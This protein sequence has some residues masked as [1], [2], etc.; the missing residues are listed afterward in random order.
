MDSGLLYPYQKLERLKK[1]NSYTT[2]LYI[3]YKFKNLS[4]VSSK[5]EISFPICFQNPFQLNFVL[6][7]WFLKTIVFF[8][9]LF[10]SKLIILNNYEYSF[11]F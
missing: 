5:V 2:L 1:Q 9:S 7:L 8:N 11:F 4:L 10:L 3:F 6:E